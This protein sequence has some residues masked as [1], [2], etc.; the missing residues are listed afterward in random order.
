NEIAEKEGT[1]FR[2]P[3]GRQKARLLQFLCLAREALGVEELSGLMTADGVALSPEDC[4]DRLFEMSAYLLDTGAQ[5]FKPWHQ[6]LVDH[7]RERV[8]RAEGAR[9][10]E[11][12][13]GRWLR[14]AAGGGDGLRHRLAHLLAPRPGGGGAARPVGPALVGGP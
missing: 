7:V 5:R 4:R 11:G 3:E 10:L 6:G 13:F 9:Q 14:A 12:V 1:R 2:S 8:L